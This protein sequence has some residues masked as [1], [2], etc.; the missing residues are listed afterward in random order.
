MYTILA[1]K[2]ASSDYCW[3]DRTDY[4]A[5]FS[6]NQASSF[7]E[8]VEIAAPYKELDLDRGEEGYTLTILNEGLVIVRDDTYIDC[9][10]ADDPYEGEAFMDALE[11]LLK[12]RKEER[13]VKAKLAKEKAEVKAAEVKRL[14][15]EKAA[16]AKAE[17]DRLAAERKIITDIQLRDE[18]L[19]KY[20][21]T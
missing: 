1:H 6:F 5:S 13:E 20:P 14:A 3:G 2:E 7:K 18:L 4:P 11:K 21:L 9:D 17:A 8:A 10:I 12:V 19:A 16:L 15:D